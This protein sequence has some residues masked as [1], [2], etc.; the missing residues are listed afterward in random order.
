MRIVIVSVLFL[1]TA[2]APRAVSTGASAQPAATVLS[3]LGEEIVSG[4]WSYTVQEVQRTKELVWSDFGNKDT[5]VGEFLIVLLQLKN[6]GKENFGINAHD[7][8]V[9]DESGT[10]YDAKAFPVG[11]N[12]WLQ[13]NGRQAL[14]SQCP[15]GVALDTGVLFDIS[16]EAAGLRLRL[17]QA[18]RDVALP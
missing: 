3:Q 9:F 2:C 14:C 5:A 6:V 7:F 13:R 12:L 10:K 4:N 17:V 1:L 15:P 18:K 16:P 8:Q 11:F